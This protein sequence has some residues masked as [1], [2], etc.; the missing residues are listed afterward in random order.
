MN[1]NQTI[2]AEIVQAVMKDV[3]RKRKDPSGD[4]QKIVDADIDSFAPDEVANMW[5]DKVLACYLDIEGSSIGYLV[6]NLRGENRYGVMRDV[7]VQHPRKHEF[8]DRFYFASQ[9]IYD[10][11]LDEHKAIEATRVRLASSLAGIRTRKAFVEMFP[12]LEKYAPEAPITTKNLPAVAN[13]MSSL[14]KLGWPEKK[15]GVP[16]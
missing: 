12:E 1:L 13:V 3:P 15:E 4:L 14:V 7:Y 16:A 2:R 8:S 10:E 6:K 11:L 9:V 5:K